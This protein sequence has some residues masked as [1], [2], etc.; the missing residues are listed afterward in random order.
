MQTLTDVC[1]SI[2]LDGL[3]IEYNH[4][5]GA[6]FPFRY[7]EQRAPLIDTI[8]DPD[9]VGAKFARMDG[10]KLFLSPAM[11]QLLQSDYAEMRRALQYEVDN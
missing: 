9:M 1:R 3:G 10:D 8:C 6:T 4:I 11:V 5:P 2:L 7:I